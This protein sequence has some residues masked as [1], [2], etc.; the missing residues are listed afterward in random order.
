MYRKSDFRSLQTRGKKV[1][2]RGWQ[3]ALPTYFFKYCFPIF[4]NRYIG[5]QYYLSTGS[6]TPKYS[7]NAKLKVQTFISIDIRQFL[8]SLLANKY[9]IHLILSYFY[10]SFKGGQNFSTIFRQSFLIV[11]VKSF[12]WLIRGLTARGHEF[13]GRIFLVTTREIPNAR[14]AAVL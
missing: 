13:S 5:A 10:F 6:T 4:S 11:L 3:D 1:S 2:N 7:A 14:R 12:F 8:V 9:L